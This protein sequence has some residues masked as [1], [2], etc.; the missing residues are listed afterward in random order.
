[1]SD[2]RQASPQETAAE[3]DAGRNSSGQDQEKA[4][5]HAPLPGDSRTAQPGAVS[6]SFDQRGSG[7]SGSGEALEDRLCTDPASG[8]VAPPKF[9]NRARSHATPANHGEHHAKGERHAHGAFHAPGKEVA[10]GEDSPSPAMNPPQTGQPQAGHPQTGQPQAG[11]P[12]TGQPQAGHPQAGQPQT[13]QPQTKQPTLFHDAGETRILNRLAPD[14]AQLPADSASEPYSLNPGLGGSTAGSATAARSLALTP[15]SC[16]PAPAPRHDA[17]SEEEETDHLV[18]GELHVYRF[19]RLLGA[20]GMGR[21][22]L[23]RHNRLERRCAVKVLSPRALQRDI[24]FVSRFRAEGQAAASLV[25]PNVVVTHAIGEERALHFLEMEY[26]SGG[27]LSRLLEDEGRLTPLRATNLT[28]RI[29]EGLG[30]AHRRGIVHRDLKTDNVMMTLGGVPKISDFG[31][32]KR[33]SDNCDAG[34]IVGTPPYMA[35]ELFSG[36]TATPASDVYALGVIYYQLLT[37]RLPYVARSLPELRRQIVHDLPPRAR[38]LVPELPLEMAECLSLMLEKCPGNRPPNGGS[39]TQL[40]LAVAGQV[41]DV[42]SLLYEAFANQP[43]VSWTQEGE[44]HTVRVCFSG[45]RK[46]DVFVEPSGQAAVDRL[47]VISSVCGPAMPQYHEQALRLNAEMP[48]GSLAIRNIDNVP[49]F[50]AM[51]TYP[52]ATVDCEEVRRSVLELSHRADM[53][54]QILTGHDLH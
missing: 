17:R 26:I 42:E 41:E 43:E 51:N 37:G 11:H 9:V 6:S 50:V 1:M 23:A 14:P 12:Q 36:A 44:R 25:H 40:L 4:Q 3:Q 24:D 7:Q 15:G 8:G 33:I 39:A 45:G 19:D 5:G 54:E 20:G 46:Q 16:E 21:V 13:G 29:A 35:P 27:S 10:G 47:L 32:A 49:M 38:D 53:L 22:Y 28:A 34:Y 31:L 18:G 48:H 2:A 30:F 52:R